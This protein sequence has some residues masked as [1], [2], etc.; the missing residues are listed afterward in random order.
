MP[1]TSWLSCR[2]QAIPVAAALCLLL[3]AAPAVAQVT[4]VPEAV[5]KKFNLDADFYKKH[6]DYKGLSILGSAKVS[7]EAML[8]ARHLI[9]QL[10]GE[11]ED[12]LKAMVKR[13]CRF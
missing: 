2:K 1:T 10:L 9:D 6:V 4:E 5:R 11:R 13:G 8:E 12:I 7:D 3:P